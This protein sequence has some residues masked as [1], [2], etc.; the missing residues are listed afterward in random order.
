MVLKM[1][2]GKELTFNNVMHVLDIQKNLV[3]GSLLSKNGFRLAFESDKFVLTK[4]GMYIGKEYMS[5]GLFK[6]NVMTIVSKMNEMK[7]VSSSYLLDYSYL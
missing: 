4:S 3:F 6:M 7:V 1:T 5:D 2:F